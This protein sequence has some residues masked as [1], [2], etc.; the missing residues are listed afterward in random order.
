MVHPKPNTEGKGKKAGGIAELRPSD[1]IAA[2]QPRHHPPHRICRNP[3]PTTAPPLLS[4]LVG[5]QNYG[6][7]QTTTGGKGKKAEN[8]AEIRTPTPHRHS[9]EADEKSP[10]AGN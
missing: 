9:Q 2:E 10:R 4:P 8:S 1:T 6:P 7:P 3:P 5:G